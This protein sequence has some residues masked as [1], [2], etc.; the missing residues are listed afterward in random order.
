MNNHD[1]FTRGRNGSP[2]GEKFPRH[3]LFNLRS[4]RIGVALPHRFA[5][6]LPDNRCCRFFDESGKIRTD[7]VGY[8]KRHFQG[9]CAKAPFYQT[10]HG[11]RHPRALA[12]S[13]IR[14]PSSFPLFTQET[15][16]LFA[17]GFIMSDSRHA[18][19]LQETG[20]DTYFSIVKY[21]RHAKQ[22]RQI[23]PSPP[24]KRGL[25]KRA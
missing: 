4:R 13:I 10:E 23:S 2:C 15:N 3:F 6:L 25:S 5:N 17:D 11:L 21:P 18:G 8:A 7:A 19:V 1:P 20:L 24:N 16:K 12:N 9:R 22:N 14:E